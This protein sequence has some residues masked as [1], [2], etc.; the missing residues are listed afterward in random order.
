MMNCEEFERIAQA[1]ARDEGLD[2]ASMEDAL[3][4]ADAC[5]SCDALLQE[6]ESLTSDLRALAAHHSAEA[7]PVRVET[8]LLRA[9]QQQREPD[10]GGLQRWRWS[11]SI[12][13]MAAAIVLVLAITD[14]PKILWRSVAVVTASRSEQAVRSSEAPQSSTGS[15][16]V[17]P[18]AAVGG[19]EG[20]DS[21][22]PLSGTF[23]LASLNEYPI[24]RVVLSSQDL[25][26]LGL[27]VGDSDDEQVVA[28]LIIA[29]DGTP[30]AIRMV[31][32]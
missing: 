17:T 9:L 2:V 29:N 28:D 24:V 15:Q 20:S 16:Q 11:A 32:W 31:S 6:A 26:S 14:R 27:P 25:Q 18:T 13:G 1:L 5:E 22:V 4:H 7:A 10:L 23:D 8:A 21:F 3:T 19:E 30:Q 12:A